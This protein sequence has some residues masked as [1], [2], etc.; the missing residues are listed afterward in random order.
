MLVS[1]GVSLL[2]A[3]FR[4]RLCPAFDGRTEP[5]N[6]LLPRRDRALTELRECSCFVLIRALL[7]YGAKL[8]AGAIVMSGALAKMLSAEPGSHFS[9]EFG[10]LCS[11]AV[12]FAP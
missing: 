2:R 1:D 12:S 4:P 7:R 3:K 6:T 5:V 8:K 11:V 9:A 10:A